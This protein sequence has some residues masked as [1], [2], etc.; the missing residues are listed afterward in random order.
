MSTAAMSA[1]KPVIDSFTPTSGPIGT[2]VTIFGTDLG[3]TTQVTFRD[4]VAA[5]FSVVSDSQLTAVVPPG[6]VKGRI[7]VTTPSAT[8]ASDGAFKVVYPVPVVTSISPAAGPV[9]SVVTISGVDLAGAT[10]VIFSA[11]VATA[12]SVVSSGQITAIVPSGA[13]SGRIRVIT[14]GGTGASATRFRVALPPSIVSV[15]PSSGIVG[16]M[17]EVFGENLRGALQL[18]FGV[19]DAPYTVV[20]DTHV[21]T[22]VPA[23]ATSSY[24]SVATLGGLATNANVFTVVHLRKVSFHRASPLV[25]T[26]RVTAIDGFSMCEQGMQIEVQRR[27]SGRWRLIARGVTRRDGSYRSHLPVSTG[28][29]RTRVARSVTPTSDVCALAISGQ[30]PHPGPPP[31]GPPPSPPPSGRT[32]WGIFSSPRNGRSSQEVIRRLELEIGRTFGG[33]RIY[34]GMDSDLP[35]ELDRKLANQGQAIYQNFSSW[36]HRGDRKICIPWAD[37]AS[38]KRDTWLITQ[39]RNIRAWGYPIFLTFTHEPTVDNAVHPRCGSPE[40]YRAAFDH[41]VHVFTVQGATN[42]SWVWTLT[43]STFGGANGGPIAWEPSHYDIVGVDGYNH[44]QRW[45]SPDE[46]FQS[47]QDFAALRQKPLLIGEI[48]SEELSGDP[49]AK[50][51]WITRAAALFRSWHDVR[52]IMWTNSGGKGGDGF[53]LDSSPQALAA[54]ADARRRVPIA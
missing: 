27:V 29:F 49:Y 37:I 1:A 13:V 35:N 5:A 2:T 51:D 41:V 28:P 48:G 45:R 52:A 18:R 54:F 11:G 15:S 17:V 23:T 24:V 38:G 32:V 42:V 40:E 7:K 3:E 46:I 22:T 14:P 33:Q 26:G 30:G 10:A 43:A 44:A 12:F 50:A 53:W 19:T 31:P 8:A 21:L 34:R 20:S 4:N 16:A 9:G 47:A 25:A 6:A 39:A 36:V